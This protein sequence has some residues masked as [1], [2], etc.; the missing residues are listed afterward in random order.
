MKPSLYGSSGYLF[1]DRTENRSLLL[2][3]TRGRRKESK[4]HLV[5]RGGGQIY[6]FIVGDLCCWIFMRFQSKT[7]LLF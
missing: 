2:L 7:P 1:K 6:G 3:A 4:Q 5:H